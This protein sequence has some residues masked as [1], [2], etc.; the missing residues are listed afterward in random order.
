MT[1]AEKLSYL[2]TILFGSDADTSKDTELNVY[3]TL[4][5]Q[6]ILN[7]KYSLLGGIPEDITEVPPAEEVTQIM[8]C[9]A[10][11]GHKG[12]PDETVHD[13]NGINRSWKH[14]D[15]VQ[16]VHANVIAYAGFPRG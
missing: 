9:A 5:A 8:A 2:K 13:E 1:D 16:Y 4:T 15:M 11:F 12:A 6:E 14:A 7:W 10:G 3:L